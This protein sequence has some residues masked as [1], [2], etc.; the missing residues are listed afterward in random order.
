MAEVGPRGGGAAQIHGAALLG[1]PLPPP[2]PH[3]M[4][5]SPPVVPGGVGSPLPLPPCCCSRFHG[6]C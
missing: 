2:Q 6:Y 3:G 5:P 1:T 4:P